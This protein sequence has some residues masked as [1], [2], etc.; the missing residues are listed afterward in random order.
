MQWSRAGLCGLRQGSDRVAMIS[1]F[2]SRLDTTAAIPADVRTNVASLRRYSKL[3][4]S[5]HRDRASA[6][7]DVEIDGWCTLL[8]TDDQDPGSLG[9]SDRDRAALVDEVLVPGEPAAHV[10]R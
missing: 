4:R 1:L 6:K 2:L 5:L 7:D 10:G 3:Q 8:R 9:G